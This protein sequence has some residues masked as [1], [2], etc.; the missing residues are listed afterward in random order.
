[1]NKPIFESKNIEMIRDACDM[2]DTSN[3][4]NAYGEL[5]WGI[6]DSGY[7]FIKLEKD[8]TCSD[9]YII[10]EGDGVCTIREISRSYPYDEIKREL[11]DTHWHLGKGKAR[12]AFAEMMNKKFG[13]HLRVFD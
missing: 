1:M 6:T 5:E 13:L 4:V 8:V 11:F 7:L 10:F 2:L 12:K 3:M 9:V